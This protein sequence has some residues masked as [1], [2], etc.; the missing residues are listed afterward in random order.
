MSNAIGL[1]TRRMTSER[2]PRSGAPGPESISKLASMLLSNLIATTDPRSLPECRYAGALLRRGKHNRHDNLNRQWEAPCSDHQAACGRRKAVR[3][4]RHDG[5]AGGGDARGN[6]KP[7]HRDRMNQ[8]HAGPPHL[9]DMFAGRRHARV[10]ALGWGHSELHLLRA[11]VAGHVQAGGG[12]G[13]ARTQ[14]VTVVLENA[15]PR[16][17]VGRKGG[18]TGDCGAAGGSARPS[19][20]L[21]SRYISRCSSLRH[22][23]RPQVRHAREKERPPTPAGRTS[24]RSR[25]RSCAAGAGRPAQTAACRPGRTAP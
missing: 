10:R 20:P 4:G 25:F 22:T 19:A 7:V 5:P 8:P 24:R 21:S 14:R 17:N 6:L 3:F 16:R 23:C 2:M 11:R 18:G 1:D 15:A 13:S 12:D 9:Q